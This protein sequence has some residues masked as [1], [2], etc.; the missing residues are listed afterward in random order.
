VVWYN[1]GAGSTS[2]L[3]TYNC[4]ITTLDTS[5]RHPL[6]DRLQRHKRS[7]WFKHVT[8]IKTRITREL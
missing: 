1:L 3:F 4:Y 7:G 8:R 5:I 6:F 2:M